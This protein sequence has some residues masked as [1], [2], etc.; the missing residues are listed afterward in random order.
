MTRN[1]VYCRTR[2]P[3]E[4]FARFKG[5]L[6]RRKMKKKNMKRYGCTYEWYSK[7]IF[8]RRGLDGIIRRARNGKLDCVVVLSMRDIGSSEEQLDFLERMQE[9]D[10]PVFCLGHDRFIRKEDVI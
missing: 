2:L 3:F 5:R 7:N 10:I 8:N 1:W 6:I 4:S 9:M